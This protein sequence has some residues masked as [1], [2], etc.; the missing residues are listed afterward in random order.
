MP[1]QAE[2]R[3]ISYFQ[4]IRLIFVKLRF[5]RE[6]GGVMREAFG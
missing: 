4:Y 1:I 5:R 6:A 2:L 3:S